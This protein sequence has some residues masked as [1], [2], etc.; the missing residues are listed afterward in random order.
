M[1]L[2]NLTTQ[3]VY[4]DW[5]EVLDHDP[6]KLQKQTGRQSSAGPASYHVSRQKAKF[7]RKF[8]VLPRVSRVILIIYISDFE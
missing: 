5:N 1:G 3:P 8:K 2:G 7:N 4:P 6:I